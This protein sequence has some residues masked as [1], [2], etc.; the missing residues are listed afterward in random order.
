MDLSQGMGTVTSWVGD[1]VKLLIGVGVLAVVARV[2]FGPGEWAPDVL[3]NLTGFIN[4]FAG[5][6]GGLITLVV[7]LSVAKR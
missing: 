1:L 3:T 5:S 7:L 4:G 2:V 6:V